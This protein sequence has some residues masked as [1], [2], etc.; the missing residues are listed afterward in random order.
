[1]M[2]LSLDDFIKQEVTRL[3]RFKKWYLQQTKNN[4]KEFPLTIPTGNEGGWDEM[5]A[6][7]DEVSEIYKMD[8]HEE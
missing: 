2:A 3:A 5:F 6:D 8:E 1:M 4:P 7:F